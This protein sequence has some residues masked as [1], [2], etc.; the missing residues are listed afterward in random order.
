MVDGLATVRHSGAVFAICFNLDLRPSQDSVC[1][2]RNAVDDGGP[3]KYRR[4]NVDERF[5]FRR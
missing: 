2:R 1:G 5:R 4:V 3:M